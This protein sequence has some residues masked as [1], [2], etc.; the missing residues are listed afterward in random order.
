[1]RTIPRL[2]T[3][4]EFRKAY[5]NGGRF[6]NIFSIPADGVITKGE[7][8]RAAG[9]FLAD[10]VAVMHFEMHRSRLPAGD[11]ARALAMLDAKMAERHRA[12]PTT[13]MRP[14]EFESARPRSAVVL[15]GVMSEMADQE[16]VGGVEGTTMTVGEV[17]IPVDVPLK[18]MFRLDAM[19]DDDAR[20]GPGCVIGHL[21][22][23]GPLPKGRV[24]VGG[25]AGEVRPPSSRKGP[26]SRYLNA[27]YVLEA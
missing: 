5:D 7:A 10:A 13:W 15:E 3:F 21:H 18:E 8:A 12:H 19:H 11:A 23:D 1:M 20:S 22:T 16:G 25:L 9:R 2:R 27:L 4:E 6:F 17:V 24:L 14:S 26:W